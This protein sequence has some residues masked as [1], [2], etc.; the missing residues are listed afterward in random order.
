MKLT[1]LSLNVLALA[2]ITPNLSAG[3]SSGKADAKTGAGTSAS[4]GLS[5]QLDSGQAAILQFDAQPGEVRLDVMVESGM[6]L[7]ITDMKGRN[8][9]KTVIYTAKPGR[10]SLDIQEA[11]RL[12]IRLERRPAGPFLHLPARAD[13]D[14]AGFDLKIV[15]KRNGIGQQVQLRDDKGSLR[16]PVGDARGASQDRAPSA[17]KAS[18]KQGVQASK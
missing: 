18:S 5:G 11:T 17:G 9:R 1:T 15:N 6:T 4:A 12:V 3:P 8:M 13:R 2:L 10:I 16:G 14:D 7:K